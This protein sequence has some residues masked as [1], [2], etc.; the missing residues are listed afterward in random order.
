M[1]ISKWL[2]FGLSAVSA[3]ESLELSSGQTTLSLLEV[4]RHRQPD[5]CCWRLEIQAAPPLGAVFVRSACL[6]HG[7]KWETKKYREEI[8]SLSP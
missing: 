1:D 7:G 5:R 8:L 2:R 4:S 3:A 6:G